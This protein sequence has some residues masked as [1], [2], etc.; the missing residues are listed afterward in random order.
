[1]VGASKRICWSLKSLGKVGLSLQGLVFREREGE[2]STHVSVY[3]NSYA[4]CVCV[5]IQICIMKGLVN[6]V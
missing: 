5:C 6:T 4:H 3:A 2:M 1:M